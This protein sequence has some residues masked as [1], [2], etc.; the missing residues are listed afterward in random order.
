V[1]D[2]NDDPP[3]VAGSLA[4]AN[5]IILR[6]CVAIVALAALFWAFQELRSLI[7][8]VLLA[9]F[10]SLALEPAV[11]WLVR[12]RGM[13]RGAA[14]GVVFVA[15]AA[16][17]LVMIGLLVPLGVELASKLGDSAPRWTERLN[18]W[19]GEHLGTS[20]VVS[21]ERSTRAGQQL[22][23]DVS[24]WIR[25][26]GGR[27]LGFATGGLSL[28]LNLLT[29][30]LF[31]FSLTAG[32]PQVRRAIASTLPGR[33]Q[34]RFLWTWDVAL[35][36]TGGYFYSRLVL[37]VVNGST[38][39]LVMVAVG[40]PVR[41]AVPLSLFEAFMAEFIPA[42]GTYIGAVV[43]ILFVIAE[44]GVAAALVV[45]VFV[46]I[47][48]QAENLWLSP[49]ISAKTMDLNAGVAFGAALAGGA[50]FGPIGA[51]VALPVAGMITS[52]IRQYGRSYAVVETMSND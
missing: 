30:G 41:Y 40:T 14:T 2:E 7:A 50:L 19:A 25:S 24:A 43:P 8:M 20:S 42:V 37:M 5:Q 52:I 23:G 10:F 32:A 44:K 35:R 9:Y 11:D 22:D 29:V 6:T 12:H 4:L 48:Q 21:R 15:V 51:F 47:Y 39:F 36:Q 33:H 28:L 27:I 31:T 1:S 17:F 34:E 13:R 3:G 26:Y 45:A 46:L 16:F 18:R 38:F 49:R